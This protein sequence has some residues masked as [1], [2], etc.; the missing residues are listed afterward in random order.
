MWQRT[1]SAMKCMIISLCQ[2]KA[3][4]PKTKLFITVIDIH[5]NTHYDATPWYSNNYTR[6]NSISLTN[7]I[8]TL[9][10]KAGLYHCSSISVM[11][12]WMLYISTIIIS[13]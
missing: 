9:I 13:H 6:G 3:K 2:T 4:T 10:Y 1:F 11:I 8:I 5:I 12:K 7:N